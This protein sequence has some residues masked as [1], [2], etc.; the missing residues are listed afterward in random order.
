MYYSQQ[1]FAQVGM[2]GYPSVPAQGISNVS[3][4]FHALINNDYFSVM[5]LKY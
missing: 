4:N 2:P 1:G 3:E 5:L